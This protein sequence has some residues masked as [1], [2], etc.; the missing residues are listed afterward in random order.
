MR[1]TL[2]PTGDVSLRRTDQLIV[3]VRTVTKDNSVTVIS[4][5]FS[6]S[7]YIKVA[8]VDSE[9]VDSAIMSFT[10]RPLVFQTR[11]I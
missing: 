3:I 1:L 8:M 2:V 6:T 4:T 7:N 10:G 5:Y 9:M 11:Y